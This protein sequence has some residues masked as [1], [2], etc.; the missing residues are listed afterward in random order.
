MAT[1]EHPPVPCL[2]VVKFFGPQYGDEK[3]QGNVSN[4]YVRDWFYAK[5][6]Q[7]VWKLLEVHAVSINETDAGL[8][9][10]VFPVKGKRET[11]S[12]KPD[13]SLRLSYIGDRWEISNIEDDNEPWGKLGIRYIP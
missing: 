6:M 3:H 1:L 11:N 12:A 9:L 13:L 7:E 10:I 4:C 5:S 2:Y 8:D